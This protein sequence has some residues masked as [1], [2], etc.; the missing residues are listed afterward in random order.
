MQ[1]RSKG[2]M[3]EE[4]EGRMRGGNRTSHPASSESEN[5]QSRSA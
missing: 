4:G 5:K 2:K 1:D 3:K